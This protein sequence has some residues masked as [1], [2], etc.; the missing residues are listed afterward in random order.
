ERQ[1][2]LITGVR[3]VDHVTGHELAIEARQ[4]LNATGPWVDAVC[5]LAGDEAGP[6]LRPTKGVHLVAPGRGLTSA[7]LLLHPRD[8]RGFL[9]IPCLGKM[10]IGTTAT[11][12]DTP[13]DDAR[14]PPEDFRYLREGHNHS[15]S[16]PLS[17]N[18]LLGPFV[19]LRPLLR[20]GPAEPSS[21]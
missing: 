6:R 16:P 8:G 2:T 7:F 21:L 9:V 17:E 10:L 11:E 1:G 13:P 20:A 14:S 5:H 19:G 12:D 18:A 3:A 4:V 15:F